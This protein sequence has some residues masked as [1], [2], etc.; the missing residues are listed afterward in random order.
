MGGVALVRNRWRFA[1]HSLLRS[2]RLWWCTLAPVFLALLIAGCT[3]GSSGG[4]GEPPAK[5]PSPLIE[6]FQ[7]HISN[8]GQANFGSKAGTP[9]VDLNLAPLGGSYTGKGVLVNVIDSGLEIAHEDLAANV[10]SGSDDLRDG[11][12]DNSDPSPPPNNSGDHGTSVAG[13]IAM[14]DN[15]IGGV[16]VAPAAQLIAHNLLADGAQRKDNFAFALSKGDITNLSF[17]A[18]PLNIQ[19][20][21]KDLDAI[22]NA[23]LTQGRSGKGTVVVKS[24]GNSFVCNNYAEGCSAVLSDP[25]HIASLFGQ[26][27]GTAADDSLNTLP[28]VVVGAVTASGKK[29]SYSTTGSAVWVSG[30]GGE[31]SFA[32]D[33]STT[34]GL[35]A[36]DGS[37]SLRIWSEIIKPQFSSFFEMALITTDRSGCTQGYSQRLSFSTIDT[38]PPNLFEY[39]YTNK[40]PV[41]HNSN[42]YCNYTSSFNGTSAAAPTVS[43]V[44][45]LMLEAN[46]NLTHWDVR[47][48]LATTSRKIDANYKVPSSGSINLSPGWITNKRGYNYSD[49]YG[50]GLVDA[51]KAVNAAKAFDTTQDSITITT[52]KDWSTNTSMLIADAP[53]WVD[54]PITISKAG[55]ILHIAAYPVIASKAKPT[56]GSALQLELISPS[57]TPCVA[58][59]AHNGHTTVYEENPDNTT[60]KNKQGGTDTL[61]YSFT[62]E[63]R[64]ACHA[65]YGEQ[66]QG[67]WKLRAINLLKARDSKTQSTSLPD[68]QATLYQWRIEITYK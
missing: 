37:K 1:L 54:S 50:F 67:E 66:M 13:I 59:G 26:S 11:P 62:G 4:S 6:S 63:Q 29:A 44:V 51:A 65:F 5:R 28:I 30:F 25:C 18:A 12:G 52:T 53:T 49:W 58:L 39:S 32:F 10:V 22:M 41:P 21:D 31:S 56:H 23:T 38:I 55:E 27:C 34:T 17:G 14:V 47:H 45:A 68:E 7:W 61:Y 60:G 43:G 46:P 2:T 16:G 33:I 35:Y 3:S 9:G 24:A 57:G 8:T 64:L 19:P 40:T 20:L 48:I 42:P 36:S 15:N